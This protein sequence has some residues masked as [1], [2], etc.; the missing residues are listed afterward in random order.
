MSEGGQLYLQLQSETGDFMWKAFTAKQLEDFADNDF[1][2][3][4]GIAGSD[5][6][7]GIGY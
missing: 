7:G 3:E 1:V 4:E 6:G 2:Y 5:N